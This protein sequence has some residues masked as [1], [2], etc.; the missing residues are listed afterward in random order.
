MNLALVGG[1]LGDGE[2]EARMEAAPGRCC[3]V[4]TRNTSRVSKKQSD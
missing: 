1:L 4:V 2:W 3:V